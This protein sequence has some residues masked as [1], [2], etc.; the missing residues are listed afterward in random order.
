MRAWIGLA[1]LSVS[2]ILGL[3]YYHRVQWWAWGVTLA[4]GVALLVGRPAH[5]RCGIESAAALAMCLPAV[6]FMPW[7]YRSAPL[8]IAVG[9]GLGLL[10][11]RQ[12]RR[13]SK[14]SPSS[15][16]GAW[17]ASAGEA[18]LVAGCTLLAQALAMLLYAV[19]TS[20]SHELPGPLASVLGAA[21]RAVGIQTG[22]YESTVAAF[23][24][25]KTHLFGATWELLLDPATWCFLVGGMVLLAW[26]ARIEM[27]CGGQ[28]RP[29][30]VA[31]LKLL[32]LVALWLP[33]RAAVLA[34]LY[35]NDVLHTD[36]DAPLEAMKLM[37]NPWV[38]LALL[39]VPVLL[40]WKFARWGAIVPPAV[41]GLRNVEDQRGQRSVCATIG[42]RRR[43]VSVALGLGAVGLFTLGVLWDPVGTRQDGRIV[44]EEY[45][46]EGDK[47][48]EP[49]DKPFDT[50]AYWKNAAYTFYCIVDYASHYY[51]VTRT[52]M[53]IDD[54]TLDACDVLV[55]KTPTR[56]YSRR[57]INAIQRFVERGGGLLLIG[58]HTD[59]FGTSTNLNS[60][61]ERFGFR[62]R[63]D[64]LFGIDSVFE[65]H[66]RRPL[67]PHPILQHMPPLDFAVSCSIDPGTSS[68]RAVIRGTGLKSKWA[69]YHADNYYP[70]PEDVAEMRYGAFV[71]LW[72]M[73]FGRGRVVAF[74]DS[75]QFSNFCIMDP[76]KTE[77][78]MGMLEWLNHRDQIGDPRLGMCV[79]GLI[80]LASGLGAAR[81]WPGAWLLLLSAGL[82]GWTSAALGVRELQQQAMPPPHVRAERPLQHVVMDR[83]VC[84]C[85]LST[86]G[87]IAGKDDEFGIF[88][89][90]ILRLGY[91]PVRRTWPEVVP[92]GMPGTFSADLLVLVY[93]SRPLPAGYGEQ[94]EKYVREGGRV[95]V[96]DSPENQDS[97]A[98]ALL[99]PFGIS[100]D[101]S[102]REGGVLKTQAKWPVAPITK[103]ATVNGGVAF[104][105]LGE[106]PIGAS[107]ACGDGSVTVIGFGS[108]FADANM[109]VT[110][111]QV[112]T[113]EMRAVYEVQFSLLRAI[114]GGTLPGLGQ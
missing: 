31:V 12:D 80:L 109:G 104:A 7:P 92:A 11:S 82:L 13:L 97:M 27:P 43:V 58:E 71:Q 64:C 59:V 102:P 83:A 110:G 8:L 112:P 77:L 90:W 98:N 61:A 26:R 89:R 86:N 111:D 84:D 99:K 15:L 18:C 101:A 28:L 46:P 57:E 24:M 75:T 3:E 33:L 74:G 47:G 72:S 17:L 34:A 10:V 39:A 73:R 4:A 81:G 14:E 105:W 21:F 56:V 36:Y 19:K 108:R 20:R 91:F 113:D 65:Q 70:Q 9:L 67:V 41:D 78:M 95:L 114:M 96:L 30:A 106:R 52:S 44:I 69:D 32:F 85:K 79:A 68:G 5:R 62:Y 22:V 100:L 66:W 6:L 60:V 103:A 51:D 53:P 63:F 55:L 35:L 45:H 54:A 76:G 42:P 107:V 88:E 87:F 16:A 1:L 48:W 25:R 40:G 49:T 29:W 50:N 38:L 93:P 2:W 94:M 23:S 37:W